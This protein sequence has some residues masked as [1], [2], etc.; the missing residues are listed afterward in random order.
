MAK[1][2]DRFLVMDRLVL[3]CDLVRQWVASGGELIIVLF[4][5][6]YRVGEG[7]PPTLSNVILNG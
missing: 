2:L 5:L 7:I 3:D 1:R 4:S 6:S